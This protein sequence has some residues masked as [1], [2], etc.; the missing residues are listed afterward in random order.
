M[1]RTLLR[2]SLT[3]TGASFLFVI[4]VP[5]ARPQS[6]GPPSAGTVRSDLQ[7]TDFPLEQVVVG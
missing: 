3:L 6:K 2:L 1:N 7:P 5:A 4:P